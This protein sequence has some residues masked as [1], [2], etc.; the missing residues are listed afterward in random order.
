[1]KE[2]GFKIETQESRKYKYGPGE[3]FETREQALDFAE[4][5]KNQVMTQISL[6]GCW[7]LYCSSEIVEEEGKYFK[8]K[9]VMKTP[10]INF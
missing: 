7:R 8:I 10:I 3:E 4:K 6:A 2:C 9:I 5:T 1:M